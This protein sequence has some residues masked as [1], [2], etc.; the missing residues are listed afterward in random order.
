MYE[1]NLKQARNC[2][3]AS[4]AF[5][6]IAATFAALAIPAFIWGSL[7]SG[8]L[9]L[10]GAMII[11]SSALSMRQTAQTHERIAARAARYGI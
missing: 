1:K 3:R 7:S 6:S 5:F 8:V 11:T 9:T 4:I 10:T 2:R